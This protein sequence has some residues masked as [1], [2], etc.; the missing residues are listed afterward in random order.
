[1]LNEDQFMALNKAQMWD[2]Y[3]KV[4]NKLSQ[5]ELLIDNYITMIH[6]KLARIAEVELVNGNS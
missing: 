4:C 6:Q 2:I 5:K 3:Q 1:M